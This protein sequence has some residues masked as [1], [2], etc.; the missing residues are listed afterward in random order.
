MCVFSLPSGFHHSNILNMTSILNRLPSACQLDIRRS[1]FWSGI[2]KSSIRLSRF[3]QWSLNM[4]R[5]FLIT[6]SV[7]HGSSFHRDHV[8]QNWEKIE[9]HLTQ[10]EQSLWQLPAVGLKTV[11]CSIGCSTCKKPGIISAEPECS[12]NV[13]HQMLLYRFQSIKKKPHAFSLLLLVCGI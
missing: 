4:S 1:L 8:V 2:S 13:G 9:D 5:L 11:V 10:S 7:P 3:Y 12:H 6:A